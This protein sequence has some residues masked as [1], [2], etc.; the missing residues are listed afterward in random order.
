MASLGTTLSLASTSS[1]SSPNPEL[2]TPPPSHTSLQQVPDVFVIPPEEEH[3]ANPPF[4]YFDAA[5]ESK[6]SLSITP[7]ID[8]LDVALGFY[9]Q[10]DG[11]PA[12]VFH[13]AF[14]NE[15]QET[16]IMPRRSDTAAVVRGSNWRDSDVVEVVKVR[17]SEGV[18]NSPA[19]RDTYALKKSRTFRARATQALRSIKNVGRTRSRT[20]LPE[21]WSSGR[22]NLAEGATEDGVLTSR[23][24]TPSL[25]RR[26]SMQL[27][28]IFTSTR[29]RSPAP[30]VPLSPTSTSS[31]EWEAVT[32]PTSISVEDCMNSPYGSFSTMN[33]DGM[34]ASKSRSFVRRISVLDL[35]KL[36]SPSTPT[37]AKSQP[38]PPPTARA[39]E[40][41]PPPASRRTS[42]RESMPSSSTSSTL[43]GAPDVFARATPGSRPHSF[44]AG[45][46][47]YALAAPA[48]TTQL[49]EVAEATDTSLELHLDSLHFDSLSFDP[50]E[51]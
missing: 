10:T 16:V 43:A 20:G 31:S 15:S 42:R 5:M 7:D 28:Q 34:T 25:V 17:K 18:S 23:P 46:T 8:A 13:R 30:D 36:F 47:S 29:N 41:V 1:F 39:K 33:G 2:F 6:K 19:D 48:S 45:A 40:N 37:E 14:G 27:S 50:D 35:H 11:N 32:R 9:Q 3:H 26:K 49:D 4:C 44:H 24:T 38:P 12:P 21:S 22:E 51:F